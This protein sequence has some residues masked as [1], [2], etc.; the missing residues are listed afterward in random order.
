MK[1]VS[2]ICTDIINNSSLET[3]KSNLSLLYSCI[4]LTNLNSFATEEQIESLCKKAMATSYN[5][6][7]I[8]TVAA[9][10][11]YPVYVNLCHSLLK[12]T[13]VEIATVSGGFPAAQ[14]FKDVKY[15]ETELALNNGATEID[16]VLNLSAFFN[17]KESVVFDEIKTIKQLCGDKH[18]KVILEIDLL[19]EKTLIEKASLISMEAGADF[20]KTSTGKDGSVASIESVYIM[21]SVIKSHFQKTGK[22]IGLKPAGGIVA[23]ED[24]INYLTI[25]NYVLGSEW[26][27]PK[28]F[29][30]GASRL[31][32]NLLEAISNS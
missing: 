16:I 8:P 15:L 5:G 12:Q 29:R 2:S 1:S 27:S 6:I 9:V 7:T 3:T 21:S 20:I 17:K 11:I 18:L 30:L 19:K 31:A 28:L 13:D 4:D 10:C 32:G 26:M 14:T 24:A 25:V 22:M 23:P